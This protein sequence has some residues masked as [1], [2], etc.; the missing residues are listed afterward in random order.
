LATHEVQRGSLSHEPSTKNLYSYLPGFKF[1]LIT[2]FPFES[3]LALSA[4]VSQLLKLPAKQTLLACGAYNL[5]CMIFGFN[6]VLDV[7]VAIATSF[8]YLDNTRANP[9][10]RGVFLLETTPAQI[11]HEGTLAQF[12]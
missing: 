10:K 5:N 6:A 12:R 7:I 3:F 8:V 4:F 2:Q 1:T 9:H 11:S